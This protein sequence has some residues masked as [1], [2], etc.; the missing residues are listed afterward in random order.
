MVYTEP[1]APDIA[2]HI[3]RYQKK[4]LPGEN[5]YQA[6]HRWKLIFILHTAI[7]VY[8]LHSQ[9]VTLLLSVYEYFY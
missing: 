2:L 6:V 1:T 7:Y 3:V 9:P 8:Y 5:T 4:S